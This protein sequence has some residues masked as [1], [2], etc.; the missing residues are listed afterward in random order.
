MPM[1]L[2]PFSAAELQSGG[3]RGVFLAGVHEEKEI[4]EEVIAVQIH[5]HP[6]GALWMEED[7]F[8]MLVLVLFASKA[9][10]EARARL[11]RLPS[12]ACDKGYTPAQAAATRQPRAARELVG[13]E[14]A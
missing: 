6:G 5:R 3:S 10:R 8:V 14:G 7:K 9:Q 1:C 11:R 2:L 12:Q 13:E 4:T